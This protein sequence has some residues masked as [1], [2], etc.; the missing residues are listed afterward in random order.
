MALTFVCGRAKSGKSKYIYDK[1]KEL[2][3]AGEEVMLIVPEQ[4]SHAAEKKLLEAVDAIKDNSVEVFSFGRLAT[5]TDKRLGFPYCEKIDAVGKVLIIE[6]IL[7]SNDFKFYKDI[8][9]KSGFLELITG[10]IG[11]FKKYMLLPDTLAYLADK[12]DNEILSMKLKELSVIYES[13]ENSILNKFSDSGDALTILAKRLENSDIY[14][15]K[16]VFFD[17]FSTFV[18]QEINVINQ[19]NKC[20]KEVCISLC[21]DSSDKNA[22]LFMPT[23]DTINSFSK[24]TK[25]E[26]KNITDTHFNSQELKYLEKNLYRF[27][28][29]TFE[30][31]CKNVSV[32]AANNPYSETER[33][34][35]NIIS[36]V[37]D[38]GLRFRD[39]GI[40]CSDVEAYSRHIERVFD[41]YNIPYFIDTK[42][43]VLNHH[44]IRFVLSLVEVYTMDYSYESIFNYLKTAFTN[45]E[46]SHICILENY[47]LK[48]RLRRSTWLDD[49]KWKKLENSFYG[50]NEAVKKIL[51]NIR[52]KY[53]M[54][55]A[56]MHENIKGR[57]LVRDNVKALYELIVKL[58]LPET[59]SAYIEKFNNEGKVRLAKEYE[60]VWET[61]TDTFDEIVYMCGDKTT[62]PDDF[63]TLLYTAFSQHKIGYIPSTVDRVIVGNTERTRA[64]GIKALFVLGVNEGVFPVAP[65]SDGV[66]SDRDKEAMKV[67]GVEFSTTSA[68]AAYYS[69]FAVYTA[70]TMPS[71]MLFISYA[72]SGN[73]FKGMRKSYIIS[74]ICKLLNITE[75]CENDSDDDSWKITSLNVCG[76]YLSEAVSR[77]CSGTDVKPIWKNVYN[78][79]SDTVFLPKIERFLNSDNIAHRLSEKNLSNLISMMSHTSVSKIQ[80]YMACHYSYFMDYILKVNKPKEEVVDSL[81]IGNISHEILEALCKE[82]SAN[83]IAFKDVNDAE[84][85]D[86]IDLMLSRHLEEISGATDDF[87]QRDRYIIKRLKNSIFL[88][89][90]AVKKH[91]SE[92]MFEP[93]GYEIEFSDDSPL[94]C[95]KVQTEDGKI[96][97]ITGKIDRADAYKT[98]D[99][100]FIRVIDYKT[101]NKTFKLDDVFYGLDVQLIVYL[102]AL[103]NSNPS[104]NYGGALYFMIDDPVIKA[105]K[106][107]SDNTVEELLES[108]LK[109]KG[110]IVKDDA[111]LSGYDSKTAAIRNKF[112]LEKFEL[113]DKYLQKLL[114]RICTD[115]TTGDIS[116]MPYKKG[117]FSPCVYCKYASVCRFDP[118]D[119]NNTYNYL[120]SVSKA[121]EIFEQMEEQVNV[122][123]KSTDS[124]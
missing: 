67:I 120:E 21:C 111:V 66:L 108:S 17:E 86:K 49:E 115:M 41:S 12:T 33:A 50:D 53:I 55:L 116:I 71:D 90:K 97:N 2:S 40:I 98:K 74:R 31:K 28:A 32:F 58:E 1:I 92:S 26:I 8:K 75:K 36:L 118:T 88:C 82:I 85:A 54:P 18:P 46:P 68:I 100:T 30:G 5:E 13:Y 15:N 109:L 52:N 93:L 105:Q 121:D 14:K 122:D 51:D 87:S 62:N 77:Y 114:S 94:G 101:G 78:Y 20:C 4:Y 102:N 56:I 57:H 119:K 25:I 96:I 73:D 47:I 27:P 84:I 95:I 16:H 7:K 44:I 24:N 29:E 61:L 80:R 104:Y 124:D 9:A 42:K 60:Q 37:R 91:I 22:M 34:A 103:V 99:G 117:G 3:A 123:K 110:M 81:D 59:I 39:I 107:I 89:F 45:A 83:G 106:H 63:L 48:T 69:Q 38:K 70:F 79:Y 65:K 19:L 76:E 35:V 10:T 72:K 113:T 23:T 112:E 6:Q 43:Q 64:D 11:E